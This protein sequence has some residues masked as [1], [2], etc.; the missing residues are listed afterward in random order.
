MRNVQMALVE[1]PMPF[2]LLGEPDLLKMGFNATR[3][4][5]SVRETYHESDFSTANTFLSEAT[6]SAV[7]GTPMI[8]I[9]TASLCLMNR[10]LINNYDE[11]PELCESDD[12]SC[13]DYDDMPELED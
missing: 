6:V 10:N 12:E 11:M 5:G 9:L 1:Q 13:T 8:G 3:H 4:L 2:I 7:T